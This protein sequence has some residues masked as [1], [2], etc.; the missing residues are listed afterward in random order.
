MN[1]SN[2]AINAGLTIAVKGN[3][4]KID[5]LKDIGFKIVDRFKEQD[6]CVTW[7]SS[8]RYRGY[9]MFVTMEKPL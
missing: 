5:A 9:K 7:Y 4:K 2:K 6:T 8:G 1:E 3:K